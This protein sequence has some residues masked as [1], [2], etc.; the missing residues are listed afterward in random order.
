MGQH[1]SLAFALRAGIEAVRLSV[2]PNGRNMH[3]AGHALFCSQPRDA[4]CTLNLHSVEII[5]ATFVESSDTVHN[6]V[7]PLHR[8]AY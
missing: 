7:C 4:G 2:R 1:A 8:Q 6:C 5:L 3:H